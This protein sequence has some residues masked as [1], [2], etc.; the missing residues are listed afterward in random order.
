MRFVR[1]PTFEWGDG[2]KVVRTRT[3]NR[4]THGSRRLQSGLAM[5][6]HVDTEIQLTK[7]HPTRGHVINSAQ[8]ERGGDSQVREDTDV[9]RLL[10]GLDVQE[11]VQ[12]GHG[13]DD[14]PTVY[15]VERVA[16][17]VFSPLKYSRK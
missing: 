2:K 13:L 3:S 8:N 12:N 11:S 15:V 16:S 14:R 7:C 1:D 17:H 5:R 4:C 6:M 9:R 10:L